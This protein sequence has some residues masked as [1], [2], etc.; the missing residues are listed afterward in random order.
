MYTCTG[1]IHKID[2]IYRV[3]QNKSRIVLWMKI[4]KKIL[5]NNAGQEKEMTKG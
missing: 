2:E 3:S 1:H 5:S 4:K